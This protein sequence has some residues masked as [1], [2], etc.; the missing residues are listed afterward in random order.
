M[1]NSR[2]LSK[3]RY[4]AKL[5]SAFWRHDFLLSGG[6]PVGGYTNRDTA[7]NW[8][9]LTRMSSLCKALS[10]GQRWVEELPAICYTIQRSFVLSGRA[11]RH[12]ATRR[13]A[14]VPG[15]RLSE[16]LF[17]SNRRSSSAIYRPTTGKYARHKR[18]K[19]Q[20]YDDT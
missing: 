9:A 10:A 8:L 16:S 13:A 15:S 14:T 3:G 2:P 1:F 17:L 6:L 19:E 20:N 18:D 11:F 5:L 4:M 7:H 12:V